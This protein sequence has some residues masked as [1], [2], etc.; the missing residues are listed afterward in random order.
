MGKW[1]CVAVFLLSVKRGS[2]RCYGFSWKMVSRP[3]VKL[4]V[5]LPD[6]H[7]EA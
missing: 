6:E 2:H 4:S 7:V 3:L 1:K 5:P